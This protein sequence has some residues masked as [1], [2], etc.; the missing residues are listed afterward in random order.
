MAFPSTS[1][2][3]GAVPQPKSVAPVVH[4][5]RKFAPVQHI[6]VRGARNLSELTDED[7]ISQNEE[8]QRDMLASSSR[9]THAS[10][11]KTWS[12]F[13]A[14]WFGPNSD[15]LPVTPDKLAAVCAQLKHGGYRTAPSYLS[16]IKRQHLELAH[17]WTE[18]LSWHARNCIAST[19]RGIGPATQ[20]CELELLAVHGL[21]LGAEPIAPGGPVRP[22]DWF[23]LASFHL[24]R[25]AESAA[26]NLND[27]SL[28]TVN[29]LETMSLPFSKMDQMGEGVKR[30]WGCT[31]LDVSDTFATACPFHSALRLHAH[32][33]SMGSTWAETTISSVWDLDAESDDDACSRPVTLPLFCDANGDRVTR[34]GFVRTLK[35]LAQL[36]GKPVIDEHGRELLGE[37]VCR[38]T[39]ARHLAGID[40][41]TPVIMLL[42]R[43]GSSVVLRYI[44]D[45]PLTALTKVYRSRMAAAQAAVAPTV[46]GCSTSEADI[47]KAIARMLESP[48]RELRDTSAALACLSAEF[49]HRKQT[50]ESVQADVG[51]I[52]DKLEAQLVLNVPQGKVHK[53]LS[54]DLERPDTW[55][56]FC[57]WHFSRKPG[58]FRLLGTDAAARATHPT[59][60]KCFGF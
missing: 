24:L 21:K 36:L 60:F 54:M 59:C 40:V 26:A 10:Q 3:S 25:G 35:R 55:T 29:K 42:A 58:S 34:E 13:H 12:F 52:R 45:A 47:S 6:T 1:S 14:R 46:V 32:R 5:Q 18:E 11:V 15:P 49:E 19:Q 7:R 44:A 22:G 27:L 20:R 9:S 2:S 28:D 4:P 41:P 38:I 23:V 50:L 33:L 8:L 57:N 51:R 39:G 17:P 43:W 37:H 56:T 53:A 48:L 30:T 16:A 31:C